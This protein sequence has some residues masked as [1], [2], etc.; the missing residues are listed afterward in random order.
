MDPVGRA[1]LLQE[2]EVVQRRCKAEVASS[3]WEKAAEEQ[4]LKTKSGL[5]L[6]VK[7]QNLRLQQK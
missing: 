6:H 4:R 5:L 7:Y 3:G 1:R 2:A